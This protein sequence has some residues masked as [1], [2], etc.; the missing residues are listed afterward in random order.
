V[1]ERVEKVKVWVETATKIVV[2]TPLLEL[3]C[4]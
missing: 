1:D 2:Q 3:L 4:L